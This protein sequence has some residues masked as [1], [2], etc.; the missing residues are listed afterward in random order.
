MATAPT[1]ILALEL[2][3]RLVHLRRVRLALWAAVGGLT[4][5]LAAQ[6]PIIDFDGLAAGTVVTNQYPGVRFAGRNPD[7][8]ASFDPVIYNPNGPTS[9]E[10]QCLSAQGSGG[11]SQEFLRLDFDRDQTEVTFVAGVRFTGGA[12]GP[13]DTLAVRYYEFVNN[14][15]V[16]RGT[17]LPIV[18]GSL[19]TDRVYVFVRVTRPNNLLFRRIEIEGDLAHGCGARFELIDDLTFQLDTTPPVASFGVLPAC[20]CNGTSIVGAAH[21]PDGDLANWQLHR[22]QLRVANAPWVLV[23]QSTTEVVDGE[24]GPW[25]TNGPDG[26]YTLRLR[27]TNACGLLSEAFAD[28][29]MD[30]AFNSL[31]LRA[32]TPGAL[33]GGTVCFDGTVADHCGGSFAIEKRPVGGA[34]APIT[35][36]QPPWVWF[37]PLGSWNTRVG[38][39]DGSYEVRVTG[40]D[41]C[42]NVAVSPLIPLVVDN[43]PPVA[44]LANVH[45]CDRVSGVV[46]V[47]GTVVD[48]HLAGWTLEYVG[49][50]A[51][52]WTLIGQGNANVANGV[53]GTMDFGALAPCAYTLRL[54]ATDATAVDCG[55]TVRQTVRYATLD[56]RLAGDMNCDGAINN[57]DI[58]A[59]VL[60]LTTGICGCP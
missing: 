53:L 48:A 57:F 28:V 2:N 29:Y 4:N 9:S 17:F 45:N 30:R 33:V 22:R 39:P 18:S 51:A 21:D 16:L 46:Q 31:A 52:D 41:D 50:S 20:V 19:S 44:V 1:D 59:F 32:P 24:L 23:R 38:A 15:Y 12:C 35:S 3:M 6:C 55:S 40:T 10:P 47:I 34:F 13:A 26:D 49:G 36:V 60:C 11:F 25:T 27:V 7:G 43:T 42:G 8:T 58:D 37:D 5:E 54:V 56:N 14:A